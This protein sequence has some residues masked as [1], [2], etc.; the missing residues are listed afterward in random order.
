MQRLRRHP[1]NPN[2]Q[3]RMQERVVQ[4]LPLERRHTT[5][6]ARL[7]VEE[8]VR[9][10]NGSADDGGSIEEAL[11]EGAATCGG[12]GGDARLDIGPEG[13]VLEGMAGAGKGGY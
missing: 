3:S 6:F 1:N 9:G 5:I 11:G 7:A 13:G 2:P 10:D 12:G 8:H 4:E